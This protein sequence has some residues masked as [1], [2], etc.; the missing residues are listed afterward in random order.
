MQPLLIRNMIS[1]I[2]FPA[3]IIADRALKHFGGALRT[4]LH[5]AR[6]VII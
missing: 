3:L 2:W 1:P 5:G 4:Q 6:M